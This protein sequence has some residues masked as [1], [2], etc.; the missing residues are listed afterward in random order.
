V[1]TSRP[2]ASESGAIC[3][4]SLEDALSICGRE[5]A[6]SA[7]IFVLGGAR[8]YEEALCSPDCAH[9]FLTRVYGSM[10]SECD[11][12]FPRRE[13]PG[14]ERNITK[15]VYSLLDGESAVATALQASG[16]CIHQADSY[17]Y[18][19]HLYSRCT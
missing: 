16:L 18:S 8:V 5:I 4:S 17:S 3:A 2:L 1:I 12:F 13:I 14:E 15:Q 7:Q 10:E 11:V 9:V 19:F 6:P